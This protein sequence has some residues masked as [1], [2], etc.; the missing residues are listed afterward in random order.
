MGSSCYSYMNKQLLVHDN[1]MSIFKLPTMQNENFTQLR[2]IQDGLAK[3]LKSLKYLGFNEG[4][5]FENVIFYIIS[6][7]LDPKT[8]RD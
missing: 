7:K 4:Q 5:L 1:I 3:K 6:S 8:I 2:L